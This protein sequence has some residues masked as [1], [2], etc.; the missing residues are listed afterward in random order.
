MFTEDLTAFFQTSDFAYTA[1]WTPAAGGGPFTLQVIFDNANFDSLIGDAGATGLRPL[2][3][4]SD[5]QLAQ[6]AGIKRND[7]LVI[8]GITYKVSDI[9]PDGTGVTTLML[10][11]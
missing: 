2:C 10:R 5:T 9:Q 8:S 11:T 7:A 3:M 1:T 4:A 6:G